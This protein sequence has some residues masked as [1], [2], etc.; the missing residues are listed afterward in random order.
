M[1]PSAYSLDKTN[2][3]SLRYVVKFQ[4]NLTTRNASGGFTEGAGFAP[5][6][7]VTVRALIEPLTARDTFGEWSKV[8]T[9]YKVT[10]HWRDDLKEDMRILFGSRVFQI[11]EIP[12]V[13]KW[14]RFMEIGCEEVFA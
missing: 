11:R 5:L 3:G 9:G 6:D 2:P 14:D 10:I 1:R 8:V 12:K 13:S 7:F 4:T